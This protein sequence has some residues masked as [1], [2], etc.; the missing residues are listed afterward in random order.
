[1]IVVLFVVSL[2]TACNSV[3][4]HESEHLGKWHDAPG[5][6]AVSYIC[7][8][9]SQGEC[10]GEGWSAW[11][12]SCYRLGDTLESYPDATQ[13]CAAMGA[14]LVS[15]ES[16]EENIHVQGLCHEQTCWIGLAEPEDSEDWF[17]P[18]GETIGRKGEW[19]GYTNWD[20]GEPNNHAGYDEDATLINF[21]GYFGRPMPWSPRQAKRHVGRWID[22]PRDLSA[23]FVCERPAD[24]GQC[25][26]DWNVYQTSCHRFSEEMKTFD[27]AAKACADQQS[28]L[29]N[30]QSAAENAIVAGLC[31]TRPC[32]IGL[33]EP[34]DSEEWLWTDGASAGRKGE[35]TGYTNWDDGEPNNYDGH[36]EDATFMN[37]WG[38]F[39]K[40]HPTPPSFMERHLGKW[41]DAGR[42][43]EAWYVCERAE[44]AGCTG[45]GWVAYSGS[46][47]RI[48][49]EIQSHTNASARCKED[50]AT[51]VRI[52]SEEENAQV[53]ELCGKRT[54][55]IGLAEPEDSEEWHWED[56]TRLGRK[57][58]WTGYT[59][60][61]GD[62]PNNWAGRDEDA[63]FMNLWLHL[64]MPEPWTQGR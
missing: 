12:E 46:C 33:S 7:E 13:E 63:T 11:G 1:M 15:I 29:V 57:G 53:Q 48:S 34:E 9:P 35:W 60:W 61:G 17:W 2:F 50:G 28:S 44:G 26:A 3:P 40:S 52:D 6:L 39:G 54:C 24:A 21:W 51:L 47:Y 49:E 5:F 59:N 4:D 25:P 41:Y 18:N 10:T 32:W 43:M 55:W 45:E 14:H 20:D 31:D 30:I 37:Y 62:E 19:S 16:L 23:W 58:E 56:G 22:G 42:G 64:D 8:R 38:Y 36:D 27:D